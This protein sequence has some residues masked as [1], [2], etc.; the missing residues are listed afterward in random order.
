M[1]LRCGYSLSFTLFDLFGGLHSDNFLDVIL[2]RK[3]GNDVLD[4]SLGEGR[5]AQVG[6]NEVGASPD[7]VKVDLVVGIELNRRGASLRTGP[8]WVSR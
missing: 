1:L 5:H 2:R 3:S 7:E 8:E 4:L 6:E